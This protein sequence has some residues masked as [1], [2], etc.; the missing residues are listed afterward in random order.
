MYF[1][2]WLNTLSA[3]KRVA[4]LALCL[5][6][7]S[8]V[9]ALAHDGPFPAGF[10]KTV[11]YSGFYLPT[12]VRFAP[13]G[14]VFIIEKYGKLFAFNGLNDNSATIVKDFESQLWGH[15]DHGMLGLAVDPQWPARPYVYVM[16]AMRGSPGGRISRIEINP[17]TDQMVGNELVLVEG[18][19]QIYPSHSVG[20]LQFGP[21]GAL[22]ATAGDAASFNIVDWGQDEPY[23]A[24]NNPLGPCTCND[25]LMEGGALRSQ[26]LRTTGDPVGLNG[27]MIRINPDTGAAMPDNPLIGGDTGD[28]R[29]IAYGLRNPFRFTIDQVTGA[30]FICDVGW[31][32][33]EEVN[34][35]PNPL[36]TPIKNFGWPC[37]EGAGTMPAYYFSDLPICNDLVDE[38]TATPPFF[39]YPHIGGAS[40]TGA[41]IYEGGTYPS[42]YVGALFIAD[43]TEHKIR[44]MYP[45]AQGVPDPATVEEFATSEINP[46]DLQVGPGGDLFYIDIGIGSLRRIEYVGAEP[47]EAVAEADVTSGPSPLMVQFS[48]LNSSNEEGGV[49]TYG[50]DFDN[51]GDF[52]DSTDGEPVFTFQSSGNYPVNLKVTNEDDL[53]DI[54][55]IIISVDNGAPTADITLPDA[56]YLWRVGDDIPFSGGA[57]DPDTGVIADDDLV[58]EFI[59]NHCVSL[60]PPDCHEH[61]MET[62]TGEASG[63]FLAIDH[64][65]PCSIKVVLTATEPGVNGL[66][67]SDEVTLLPE[68]VTLTLETQPAGLNA[69]IFAALGPTPLVKQAVVNGSTTIT[70]QTPQIVGDTKY[71]FASWSDAGV[72]AHNITIPATDTTYTATFSANKRPVL[73]AVGNKSIGEGSLLEF[74]VTA[75]DP[76]GTTPVLSASNLPSGAEF[77]DHG[78]GSATFSWTPGYAQAGSFPNVN[79]R[80][81]DSADAQWFDLEGITI[82]VSDVNPAPVVA[83]IGDKSVNENALLQFTVSA[84]DPDGAIPALTATNVPIGASFTDNGNGTGTFAWTPT[85]AQQGTY[86]N[87]TFTATDAGAPPQ[88]HDR[89]ITITVNDQNRAPVLAAIGNQSINEGQPLEVTVS[90]SDADGTVPELSASNMPQGASFTDHGDGTGTFAWTPDF[91]DAGVHTGIAIAATDENY[92]NV[93]DQKTFSVTVTNVNRKPVLN[94]IGDVLADEGDTVDFTVIGSDPDQTTPALSASNLPQGATFTDNGN[95]T[96]KFRWVVSYEAAGLSPYAVQFTASDGDKTDSKSCTITIGNVNRPVTL[97]PIGDKGVVEG[98]LLSFAVGGAD[99]DGEPEITVAGMPNGA[100]LVDSGFGAHIFMWTPDFNAADNSPYS[101]TFTVTDG[102]YTLSETIEIIVTDAPAPATITVTKP[103]QGSSTSR[104]GKQKTKIRWSSTGAVGDKVSIELW[105]NGAFVSKIKN[106]QN[107]DGA[108]N[109]DVPNTTP[110]GP[111]YKVRVISKTNPAIFGDSGSFTILANKKIA[112]E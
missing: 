89:S 20:D 98:Q 1:T 38:G 51:D 11:L 5:A 85:L 71:T 24:D 29:I 27:T 12:A 108:F 105:R 97:D 23:N 103:A 93:K 2:S 14:H 64:E 17:A 33:W 86:T 77:V 56:S 74:T 39:T 58:W 63:T 78:N 60:S 82:G 48:A 32:S 4:A 44:V 13:D 47:P 70:A 83:A 28:D 30:I 50:W 65:Y 41:A 36:A 43:Y 90:A 8:G 106:G 112:P 92:P 40:A 37:Y 54:D 87:V 110:L 53:F 84:S 55:T 95:G 101:V 69:G 21:D 94:A 107:N 96:G 81:V 57:V 6:S 72:V 46:V 76:D 35:I 109:W 75:T 67:D 104:K 18:W 73:A 42:Q 22:Y 15:H 52:S 3:Y 66:S 80:A 25:P 111:G 99:P 34:Y 10:Q 7:L 62:I 26:D 79:I 61:H 91:T 59:L 31:N 19:C 88:S 45:D 68:V 102:E 49:L 9:P 16:Y 100:Q